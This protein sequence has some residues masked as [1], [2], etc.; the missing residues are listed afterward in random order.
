MA[1]EAFDPLKW[2]YPFQATKTIHRDP[3]PALEPVSQKDN[4]VI[5]TGAYGTIGKVKIPV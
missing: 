1:E 4:I 3:Y 5:I 2:T